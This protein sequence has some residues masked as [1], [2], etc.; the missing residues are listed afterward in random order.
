MA[1]RLGSFHVERFPQ[2]FSR[3][4]SPTGCLAGKRPGDSQRRPLRAPLPRRYIMGPEA[5]EEAP[6]ADAWP[7]TQREPSGMWAALRVDSPEPAALPAGALSLAASVLCLPGHLPLLRLLCRGVFGFVMVP[8]R[9][10]QRLVGPVP[11]RIAGL[12]PVRFERIFRRLPPVSLRQG[13]PLVFATT[14]LRSSGPGG[15]CCTATP[16]ALYGRL[17]VLS[18]ADRSSSR[19][20]VS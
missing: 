19:I 5:G 3:P 8:S 9:S 13:L 14:P 7:H 6:A 4:E 11:C 10:Y 1:S 20:R 15:G 18:A 12:S 17:P 2:R 16:P